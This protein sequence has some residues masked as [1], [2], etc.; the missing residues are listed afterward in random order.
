MFYLFNV[1]IYLS[2]VF[3]NDVA[4]AR[5]G[6]IRQNENMNWLGPGLTEYPM[7]HLRLEP[8][9]YFRQIRHM[10]LR[11]YVKEKK[12]VSRTSTGIH[13]KPDTVCNFCQS[14]SQ[15]QKILKIYLYTDGSAHLYGD[16]VSEKYIMMMRRK[17]K[18]KN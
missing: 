17:L 15:K 7:Y 1:F 16:F 9:T 4:T 11:H 12:T 14:V 10:T 6:S 8:N 13:P 3:K 5:L 18:L 2:T